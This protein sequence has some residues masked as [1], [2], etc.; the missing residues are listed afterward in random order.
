[1]TRELTRHPPRRDLGE[2]CEERVGFELAGGEAEPVAA[3]IA[4][5]TAGIAGRA[6]QSARPA[7]IRFA[8]VSAVA[9]LSRLGLAA[10]S[11]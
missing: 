3:A 8:T 5:T 7:L 1:M 4:A 2:D 9:S 11:L 10:R 6:A